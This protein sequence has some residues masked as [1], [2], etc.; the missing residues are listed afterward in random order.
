MRDRAFIDPHSEADHRDE[1][2]AERL[3]GEFDAGDHDE[4]LGSWF[5]TSYYGKGAFAGIVRGAFLDYLFEQASKV[6]ARDRLLNMP[7]P[8]GKLLDGMTT[9]EAV[10]FVHKASQ[11]QVPEPKEGE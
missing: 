10:D 11:P 8:E 3:Q 4:E 1:E 9:E 2:L 5:R 7:L 6:C